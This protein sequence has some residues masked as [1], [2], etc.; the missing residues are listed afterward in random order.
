LIADNIFQGKVR[1]IAP[2]IDCSDVTFR[3]N[4]G[5]ELPTGH[6]NR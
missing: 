1:S 4:E 2:I 3:G 5:I 6:T